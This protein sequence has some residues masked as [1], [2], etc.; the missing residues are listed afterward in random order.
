MKEI[1]N[2][3]IDKN[4][5][6]DLVLELGLVN[7]ADFDLAYQEAREKNM[8]I[9]D[10]LVRKGKLSAEELQDLQ[11][12]VLG[13]SF[14]DLQNKQIEEKILFSIPEPISRQY[15][16]IAFDRDTKNLKVA[17]LSLD[18]LDKIDFLKKQ[19]AL[20]IV[21]FLTDKISI[22]NGLLRYQELLKKEYGDRL[23][24]EFLSF[25]TI[26]ENSIKNLSRE[27]LLE[28][29][30]NKKINFVFELFL[31]YALSQN[32]SNIHIE[33]QQ[34]NVL[35]KYRIGGILYP[36]MVLSKNALVILALKIKAMAGMDMFNVSVDDNKR[37]SFQMGFDGREID[38]QVHII[39]SLWGERIVLNVLRGG[40]SGFSLDAVGFHGRALDVLYT[41]LDKKKKM[42]L[43]AGAE[44]SGKTT[45]FYTFLDL[46]K[47]SNASI[48][49]IEN[50]IGFQM[51]GISQ[52]V[53]NP[54][55]SFGIASGVKKLEK[56]NVDIIGVD[57]L[58]DF[59]TVKSLFGN[60]D[61]DRFVFAVLE[62]KEISSVNIVSKLMSM[63]LS[64]ASI[65]ANLGVVILQK[66]VP[67]LSEICRIS[68]QEYYL[69]VT[70]IKRL[71]KVKKINLEKVMT[72]LV[73]E[74]IL[75]KK[76]SWS[77]VKFYKSTAKNKSGEKIMVSEVLKIS[78]I[79]KE[80]ILNNSAVENLETQ[81]SEEGMLSLE[82]DM[83]FRAVQG[84]ISI[85]EI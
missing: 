7:R 31:K 74:N 73:E 22:N 50:S 51:A 56:Q 2:M 28:L 18:I 69:S 77:Q 48:A 41:E 39:Q 14:V 13:V 20:R 49:T 67:K 17:V 6:V 5:M 82:E 42:I 47:Y 11:A 34:D 12:K 61:E 83:L 33:P 44:K 59:K 62:T 21:P 75:E 40:D 81:A 72:A 64:P 63:E 15:N 60:L 52:V 79:I 35:I 27:A 80:L 66:L 53:T 30:R 19:V 25:Q 36:A 58:E 78:P 16:I 23:Q 84:F 10:V 68:A 43:I 3:F 1:S 85:D 46:L 8:E 45:S 71:S 9:C 37:N 76:M 70:E 38:F 24:K 54:D 65:A 57:E 29:A 26:S 32:A 4:K 55:I